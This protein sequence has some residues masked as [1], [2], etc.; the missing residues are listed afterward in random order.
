M[1]ILGLPP[2]FLYGSDESILISPTLYM[3][4][5][6]ITCLYQP[7]VVRHELIHSSR[8]SSTTGRIKWVL[9]REEGAKLILLLVCVYES[10]VGWQS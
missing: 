5:T 8:R 4:H 3:H 7:I 6:L 1:V 10:M 9:V 2:S